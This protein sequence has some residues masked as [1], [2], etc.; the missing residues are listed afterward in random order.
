MAAG[1]LP[2]SPMAVAH[3]AH[4]RRQESGPFTCPAHLT[5]PGKAAGAG[6]PLSPPLRPPGEDEEFILKL[7]NRP[8][9]VLRGLDGFV[10]HR[11]GSNQLDTNRSVYDVFRLSFSD[12]AYHI[13]GADP[14]GSR[15]RGGAAIGKGPRGPP[16]TASPAPRPWRRLLVH[17]QPRQRVQRRRARRGLPLRVPRARPPGHPRPERQVPARRRLGAAARGRGRSRRGRAL[18]VL[19]GRPAGLSPIKP[20]LCRSGRRAPW[21]HRAG[22]G[23]RG[24]SAPRPRGSFGLPIP[25]RRRPRAGELGREEGPAGG[26]PPLPSRAGTARTFSG[27]TWFPPNPHQLLSR[28]GHTAAPQHPGRRAPLP[29]GGT[30]WGW[31]AWSETPGVAACRGFGVRC[32]L[33]LFSPGAGF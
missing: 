18:G 14:D 6:S 30:G 13:R 8:I 2:R 20:C 12:G 29:P 22:R 4:K 3:G 11:R 1:P 27:S 19:S 33:T 7:I 9:L 23:V 16:P 5:Q 32:L 26:T 25:Q 28:V 31:A 10:C 21:R 17:R 24:G 15:G